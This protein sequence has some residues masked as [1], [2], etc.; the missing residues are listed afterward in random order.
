MGSVPHMNIIEHD[1]Q[2]RIEI[3]AC[4]DFTVYAEA[5]AETMKG[6]GLPV[7]AVPERSFRTPLTNWREGIQMPT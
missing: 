5:M 3:L 6:Y 7:T 1:G 2:F 4:A